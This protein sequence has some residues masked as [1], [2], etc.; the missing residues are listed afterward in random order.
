MSVLCKLNGIWKKVGENIIRHSEPVGVIRIH[1]GAV[2]PD[3]YMLCHG[4]ILNRSDYSDLYDVIG[5]KF[6]TGDGSTGSFNL[7]DLQNRTT[8]GVGTAAG[9]LNKVGT[10]TIGS[11]P[12]ITGTFNVYNGWGLQ[13]TTSGPF[14]TSGTNLNS[15]IKTGNVAGQIIEFFSASRSSSIYKTTAQAVPASVGVE[16]I[17]KVIL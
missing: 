10:N 2:A 8:F 1:C 6:G 3:G 4:Q 16:Y 12:N 11:L 17:I 7:P 13:N 14:H 5:T 9:G 15:N